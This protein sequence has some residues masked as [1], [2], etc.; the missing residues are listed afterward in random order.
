MGKNCGDDVR[1][2]VVSVKKVEFSYKIRHASAR[3]LKQLFINTIKRIN[4][5]LEISALHGINFEIYSGDVLGIVGNNGAGKS[6][7]LKIITGIL[8][9]SKGEVQVNGQV[10]PIIELGMGFNPELTCRENIELLGVLFGFK[11][12]EIRK[13][14]HEIADW[15]GLLEYLDLPIRTFSTGMIARLAFAISTF[16]EAD[17]L[18]VDEVLSVGDASF[19]KKSLDRLSKLIENGE[20]AILVSH[21]LSTIASRATKVLWLDKGRQI[22]FGNSEEVLD[23]YRKN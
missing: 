2:R 14:V 21:D 11:L 6:T 13:G 1:N 5:D 12:N 7:L 4:S 22:M 9:P 18:I 16:K 10:M 8:P 20:A 23:A 19:Q 3:T 17:L 15:A